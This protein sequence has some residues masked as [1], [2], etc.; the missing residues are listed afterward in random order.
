VLTE[1]RV[2]RVAYQ[3]TFQEHFENHKRDDAIIMAL[4]DGY[5]QA[6]IAQFIGLSRSMVC[7]IIKGMR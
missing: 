2:N 6:K 5:T 1:D 3:K 4:K 7:K